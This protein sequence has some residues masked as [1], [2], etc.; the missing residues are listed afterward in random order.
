M[1][2]SQKNI[3]PKKDFTNLFSLLNYDCIECKSTKYRNIIKVF[4][5]IDSEKVK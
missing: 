5:I 1:I 4:E 3:L 2:I